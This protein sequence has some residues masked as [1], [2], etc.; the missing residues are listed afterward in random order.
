M[1]IIYAGLNRVE[2]E[3]EQHV[4]EHY[5]E[6]LRQAAGID[7]LEHSLAA[8]QARTQ[9]MLLHVSGQSHWYSVEWSFIFIW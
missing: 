2:R 7:N 5:E 8:I 4:G 9:V 1:N 6:L 3:L